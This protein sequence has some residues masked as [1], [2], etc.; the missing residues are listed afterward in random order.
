MSGS[1]KELKNN[2]QNV[3]ALAAKNRKESIMDFADAPKLEKFKENFDVSLIEEY[4]N[5]MTEDYE[6]YKKV[7][8]AIDKLDRT[9]DAFQNMARYHFKVFDN[10]DYKAYYKKVLKEIDNGAFKFERQSDDS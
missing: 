6:R 8:S 7:I 10:P 3:E 4:L 5:F 9:T 2:R 1:Q